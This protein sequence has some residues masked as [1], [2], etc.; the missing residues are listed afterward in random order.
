MSFLF[1]LRS[2]AYRGF[3]VARRRIAYALVPAAVVLLAIAAVWLRGTSGLRPVRVQHQP[4]RPVVQRAAQAPPTPKLVINDVRQ[5]GQVVE[6]KGTTECDA[7]LMINGE[8]VPLIF[9]N[10]GFKHFVLLPDGPSKI[11]VT[12]QGPGGGVNTKLISVNI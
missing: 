6:L 8:R 2:A 9:D 7:A 5:T 10:C 11:A 4:F 1:L 12:A 3:A